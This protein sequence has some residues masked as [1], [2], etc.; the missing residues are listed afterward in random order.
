MRTRVNRARSLAD[1]HGAFPHPA[2]CFLPGGTQA[3]VTWATRPAGRRPSFTPALTS[4][5]L[6]DTDSFRRRGLCSQGGVRPASHEPEA[7]N[8]EPGTRTRLSLKGGQV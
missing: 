7:R 5:G 2:S 8:Q 6:W 1:W 4:R 3:A